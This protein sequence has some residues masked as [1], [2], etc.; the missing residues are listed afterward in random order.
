VHKK[1]SRRLINLRLSHC[2]HLD[3]FD[4]VFNFFGLASFDPLEAHGRSDP[5]LRFNKKIS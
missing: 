3:Y 4:N 1:D 2:S 5:A